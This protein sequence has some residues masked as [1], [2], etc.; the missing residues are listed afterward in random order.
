MEEQAKDWLDN[1]YTPT[2][3]EYDLN[4][5]QAAWEYYTNINDQTSAASVSL[6][7]YSKY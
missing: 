1:V 4:S 5:T 2:H 7:F 6:K 3:T